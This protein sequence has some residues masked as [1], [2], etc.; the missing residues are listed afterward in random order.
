MVSVGVL[1]L[2]TAMLAHNVDPA[3]RAEWLNDMFL[4]SD[5]FDWSRNVVLLRNGDQ[6]ILVDAGLGLD[7]DLNLRSG[8]NTPTGTTAFEHD[9]EEATRV[10]AQSSST[11]TATSHAP[12][13]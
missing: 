5:A 13:T 11:G 9:P 2:S 12:G 1:S 4:P 8:S 10:A 3:V 7:P 6:T